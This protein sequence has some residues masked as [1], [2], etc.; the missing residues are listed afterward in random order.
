MAT[1]TSRKQV[2]RKKL[3]IE[4][5]KLKNKN[6]FAFVRLHQM[7]LQLKPFTP[8]V[9]KKISLKQFRYLLIVH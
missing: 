8:I 5:S 3:T 4:K 2:E 1:K 9:S 6:K 7:W